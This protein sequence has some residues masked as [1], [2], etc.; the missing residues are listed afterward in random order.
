MGLA[1]LVVLGV[2][3]RVPNW[4]EDR[5]LSAFADAVGAPVTARTTSFE[6]PNAFVLEGVVVGDTPTVVA[7]A[8]RVRLPIDWAATMRRRAPQFTTVLLQTPALNLP[9]SQSVVTAYPQL[10]SN[11]STTAMPW[12]EVVVEDGTMQWT[13]DSLTMQVQNVTLQAT[14]WSRGVPATVVAKGNAGGRWRGHDF[15]ADLR[16]DGS[17]DERGWQLGVTAV[18]GQV[19]S[20]GEPATVNQ[21]TMRWTDSAAGGLLVTAD[22]VQFPPLTLTGLDGEILRTDTGYAGQFLA[23][24][25]LLGSAEMGMFQ[26]RWRWQPDR[27]LAL[28]P[29]RVG[30]ENGA[31]EGS[32][33]RTFTDSPVSTRVALIGRKVPL[34]PLAGQ[35]LPAAAQACRGEVDARVNGTFTSFGAARAFAGEIGWVG[36]S[37]AVTFPAAW[38]AFTPLWRDDAATELAPCAMAASLKSTPRLTLLST[39]QVRHPALTV[40]A[41][42]SGTAA[43]NLQLAVTAVPLRAGAARFAEHSGLDVPPGRQPQS[44]WQV[45]GTTDNPRWEWVTR[46]PVDT[47]TDIEMFLL[48]PD[49]A[50]AW[51]DD[52]RRAIDLPLAPADTAA[53]PRKER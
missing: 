8:S 13:E 23:A 28:N 29:L 31:W 15:S 40:A 51:E 38:D 3:S 11:R 32:W 39:L 5:A 33:V 21:L 4:L 53:V 46:Y 14:D 45:A 36:D 27:I 10:L 41:S 48:P 16:L 9:Y 44:R 24:G 52:W 37:L 42:G 50:T 47:V 18:A 7:V 12:L 49:A 6:W 2:L 35:L 30:H 26:A 1:L 22:K 34:A 17:H 25:S 20:G 43:G 19:T